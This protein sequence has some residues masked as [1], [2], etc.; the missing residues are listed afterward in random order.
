MKIFFVESQITAPDSLL[1][2]LLPDIQAIILDGHQYGIAQISS[3]LQQNPQIQTVHIV[4][5]GSPGCL[6]LGNSEL[7]LT[8]IYQYQQLLQHWNVKNIVLYGCNVAAGDAGSEF[9]HKLH[10]ITKAQITATATKTGNPKL[11]GNWH[12]EVNYPTPPLLREAGGD[13]TLTKAETPTTPLTKAET[14]T[15]PLVRGAGQGGLIVERTN[16]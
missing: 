6:Y 16:K 3:V 2:G 14:L 1:T 8:N 15:P 10:K 7:N 9:I 5:H 13:Q 12:L 4:S 11:G